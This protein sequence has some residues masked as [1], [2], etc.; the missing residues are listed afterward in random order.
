M[1]IFDTFNA[2]LK[3]SVEVKASDIHVTAGSPFRLRIQGRIVPVQVIDTLKPQDTEVIASEILFAAKK[4]T[5]DNLQKVTEGLKDFDCS[6][7]LAQVSRF[8]VN[9]C[10]QRGSLALVL[11]T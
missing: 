2:V 11:R 3:K 4:A 5:R 10:S 9:I 7:S 6:Y 8:R 1:S